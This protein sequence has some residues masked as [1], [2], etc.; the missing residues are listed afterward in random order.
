MKAPTK[1]D[2]KKCMGVFKASA[3]SIQCCPRETVQFLL[4]TLLA[5]LVLP[6]YSS[7]EEL[8]ETNTTE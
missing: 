7:V 2:G 6:L 5:S 8:K 3:S 1:S 4:R